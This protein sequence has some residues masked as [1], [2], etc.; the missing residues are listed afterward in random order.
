MSLPDFASS[1]LSFTSHLQFFSP[2]HKTR[3]DFVNFSFLI[4]YFYLAAWFDCVYVI[5]NN[6]DIIISRNHFFGCHNQ[7]WQCEFFF[8]SRSAKCASSPQWRA[9]AR[10]RSKNCHSSEVVVWLIRVSRLHRHRYSA[11]VQ[12]ANC[13]LWVW[14]CSV[15]AWN[16]SQTYIFTRFGRREFP[17]KEF[18]RY[19]S[20]LTNRGDKIVLS[21][22]F[23]L[24]FTHVYIH[25]FSLERRWLDG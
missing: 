7:Q 23:S 5:G 12:V 14:R 2:I 17:E 13:V 16:L 19:K 1:S 6:N 15:C 3:N 8:S 9:A 20:P 22:S 18:A 4:I 11:V 24:P 25:I 21:H 10:E